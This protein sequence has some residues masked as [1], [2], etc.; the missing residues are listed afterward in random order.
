MAHATEEQGAFAIL[1]FYVKEWHKLSPFRGGSSLSL[2][3]W[4][5]PTLAFTRKLTLTLAFILSEAF[6]DFQVKFQLKERI[7]LP[8]SSL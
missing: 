2:E 4:L 6:Y 8:L 1:L 3:D 7:L 5:N